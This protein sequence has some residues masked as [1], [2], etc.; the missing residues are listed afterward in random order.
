MNAFYRRCN[1]QRH[2]KDMT[3]KGETG[4]RSKRMELLRREEKVRSSQ[5]VALELHIPFILVA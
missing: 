3:K 5:Q 2:I 4:R 1:P